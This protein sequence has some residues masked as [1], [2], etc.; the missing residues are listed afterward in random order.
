MRE[1]YINVLK[2]MSLLIALLSLSM[3]MASV[4]IMAT[5]VPGTPHT[6]YGFVFDHSGKPLKDASVS[7][8][9]LNTSEGLN[10]TTAYDGSYVFELAS[11]QK[12]YTDGDWLEI[13]A[14]YEDC[15][16]VTRI[17]VDLSGAVQ[18]AP[19]INIILLTNFDTGPGSY[20]SIFG[21]HTGNIIPSHNIK[22]EKMFTYSCPGTGGHTEY[23]RIWNNSGLDRIATWS[24]YKDNWH[25]ITFNE[26][27]VLYKGE[28]YNYT[29]ITGSYPQIIHETPFNA[30]GG[31]ITCDKFIDA[32]GMVYYDWIP[33]FRL[34]F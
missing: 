24:G 20:P 22:V 19:D 13:K 16:A 18:K 21:V 28:I 10:T 7:L 11:L 26:T 25:N 15:Y 2:N 29:I 33:A 5:A 31:T 9:N 14:T 4:T 34:Y 17:Y 3:F 23:A 6:V 30:T 27:F 12:G 32:N 8:N 1:T